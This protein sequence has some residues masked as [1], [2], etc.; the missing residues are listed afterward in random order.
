MLS[1]ATVGT[2]G[3]GSAWGRPALLFPVMPTTASASDT[4]DRQLAAR[5]AAGDEQALGLLYDRFGRLAYALAHAVL[6]EP[7]DAEE[8]VGDAFA[9]AWRTAGQFDPA[10][11][12][13]QAWLMTAVRSRALDRLRTRRRAERRVEAFEREAVGA[14]DPAAL[15]GPLSEPGS[16]AEQS[17]RRVQIQAALATLPEAQRR[18]LELAYFE[19][20][21]QVEM[22][23]RLGEPLGTI[24]TRVRTALGR[25]RTL[26]EPLR[27]E[28][29][30]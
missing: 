1:A 22:A 27:A 28:G 15:P 12:S 19:G 9:Q 30:L 23:E 3:D 16:V 7:A 18:V 8:A 21:T 5:L 20:L 13:L 24:K 14:A 2:L 11:G 25:L 17:D 26:L 6:R 4:G 29:A 10:R